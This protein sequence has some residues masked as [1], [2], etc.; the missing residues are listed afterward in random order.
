MECW[1]QLHFLG[2]PACSSCGIPLPFESDIEQECAACLAKPPIHDGIVAVTAYSDFSRQVILK[3]KH[4]GKIG[5][6]KMIADHLAR[7]LPEDRADMLI[8][9]VPLH[10]TR[11]WARSFNQA[12]LIAGHLASNS[13]IRIEPGLLQRI[14]RT[15]LL[16]GKSEK[17]RR[18]EVRSAFALPPGKAQLVKERDILLVD[19]VYTTGATTDACVRELKKAGAKTVRIY[20]WARVLREEN[21]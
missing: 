2:P 3:L 11:L 13:G 1:R 4:G 20:C 21:I 12:A 16:R 17:E 7:Q 8:A 5:L 9:P 6:A 15:E 14:K 18:K 10:W 19:D